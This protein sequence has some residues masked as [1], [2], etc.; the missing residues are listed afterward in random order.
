[1]AP[2]HQEA[3]VT[4]ESEMLTQACQLVDGN[5]GM[6]LELVYAKLLTKLQIKVM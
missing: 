4:A 6:F 3:V 2:L 1:M 5:P